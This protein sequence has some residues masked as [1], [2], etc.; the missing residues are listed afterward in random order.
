[1]TKQKSK[2]MVYKGI[3]FTAF[4]SGKYFCNG[5]SIADC[6]RKLKNSK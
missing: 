3:K 1:M 5:R 4:R 2:T 6:K